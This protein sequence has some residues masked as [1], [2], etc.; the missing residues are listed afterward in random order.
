MSRPGRFETHLC[1][2]K[3]MKIC[4]W[5]LAVFAGVFFEQPV[6]AAV[7]GEITTHGIALVS[8]SQLLCCHWHFLGLHDSA[9]FC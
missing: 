7:V 4:S 3:K 2:L 8:N 9:K 6:I 1:I 5:D